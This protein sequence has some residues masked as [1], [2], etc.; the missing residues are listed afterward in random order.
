MLQPQ[1]LSRLAMRVDYPRAELNANPS[2]VTIVNKA[3]RL[4]VWKIDCYS[5]NQSPQ[6]AGGKE[7]RRPKNP[8]FLSTA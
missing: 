6:I 2:P 8:D 4:I 3:N 1:S 5:L 7:R